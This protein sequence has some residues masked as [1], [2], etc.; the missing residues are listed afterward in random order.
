MAQKWGFRFS[1]LAFAWMFGMSAVH[2]A[3]E[4]QSFDVPAGSHPHDVAP[5]KGSHYVWYTAQ[6]RGTIGR[7]D[8][9]T[10][11]V[12]EIHLGKDSAPHG[13]IF[14]P[15][16]AIW[17]ADGGLNA[18]V[19][20]EPKTG[21]LTYFYL[22]PSRPNENLN[23]ATFDKH[24]ILWFTGQTGIYGRIDPRSSEIKVFDAPGGA[25]PYGMT[26]TPSG[27]IYYASFAGSHI[28]R[29]D[30]ATGAAG[31][32]NPPTPKQGSR[33]LSAD[34]TGRLWIA[35]WNAGQLSAYEPATGK[36]RSWPLPGD[37]PKPY[38]IYVDEK[39]KVWLSDFAA[40]AVLRFDPNT[41]LFE[42]FPAPRPGA[43][44][45]QLSGR[46]GEVW[47]A[48]SGTDHLVVYRTTK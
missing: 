43:D 24:G 11:A 33:R 41:N 5:E 23:S 3:T 22:S 35:E 48:E 39:D 34:S 6:G 27:D 14:G 28:A 21:G 1:M 13:L 45:R 18:I 17:V 40:N 44:I 9:K 32:I 8:P 12:K 19:R 46:E 10:K 37:K 15:D 2:A 29:I 38:G 30:T 16:N 25:G 20:V 47:G 26:A 31:V 36:W 7:L 42:I 4:T